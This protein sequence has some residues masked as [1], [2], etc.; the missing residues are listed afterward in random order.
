MG[1]KLAIIDGPLPTPCCNGAPPSV[2]VN[3]LLIE[4]IKQS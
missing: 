2:E 4:S 3:S 1:G